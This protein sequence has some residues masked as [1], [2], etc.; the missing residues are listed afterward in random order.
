MKGKPA[1]AKNQPGQE[2]RR[3]DSRRGIALLMI[4][5][6]L[7]VLLITAVAF[8][9]FM[10]LE[11]AG[12]ANY[13]H[14]TTARHMLQAGL[15][16]AIEDIHENAGQAPYP[17]FDRLQDDSIP[18]RDH[19]LPSVDPEQVP[20]RVLSTETML[21]VPHFLRQAMHKAS[22]HWVPVTSQNRLVGRYAYI[23]ANVSGL[24][25]ANYAGGDRD[26]EGN[27]ISRGVGGNPREIRL[28]QDLLPEMLD[29]VQFA[30]ER[31]ER[32]GRYE[33][34]P[35]LRKLN[36]G[37][38]GNRLAHFSVYSRDPVPHNFTRRAYI[39]EDFNLWNEA[40]IRQALQRSG[41]P[42]LASP[43][44]LRQHDVALLAMRDFVSE[45]RVPENFNYPNIK[46]VPK[47]CTFGVTANYTRYRIP[48]TNPQQY[49]HTIQYGF[50]AG[51]AVPYRTPPEGSY[52][53]NFRFRMSDYAFNVADDFM[54]LTPL[55]SHP[56][57]TVE[58]L[59][60][61]APAPPSAEQ[62]L[63]HHTDMQDDNLRYEVVNTDPYPEMFFILRSAAEVH[64]DSDGPVDKA[65]AAGL[66]ANLGS[67]D[68][69]ANEGI[70]IVIAIN[71]ETID[72][73]GG[74]DQASLWFWSETFDPR[75]NWHPA[76]WIQSM[77]LDA[78]AAA[79]GRDR[80]RPED[81]LTHY[82][83]WLVK[84][85]FSAG[86]YAERQALFDAIPSPA[87][88]TAEFMDAVPGVDNFQAAARMATTP[89]RPFQT[90][91]E[92]G[93]I[94][95]GPWST[96]RL[97]GFRREQ[98]PLWS[99]PAF[100]DHRPPHRVLDNFTLLEEAKAVAGRVNINTRMD[101]VLA[102]VFLDMPL[103]ETVEDQARIPM[104]IENARR[105][106]QVLQAWREPPDEEPRYI[107]HLSD[108]GEIFE[109]E[110]GEALNNLIENL[111]EQTGAAG[112][113]RINSFDREAIIRNS[114]GLFSLR[115]QLYL[116][117]MRADAFAPRFGFT[118]IEQGTVLAT[119]HAVALVW[120]D[121]LPDPGDESETPVHPTLIRMFNMLEH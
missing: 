104:D 116:V 93:Y 29:P 119:G 73:A 87:L 109:G 89:N 97:D 65:P 112:A 76:L 21:H 66:A 100:T 18:F 20:A 19:V 70:P 77:M 54:G 92:L 63:Y 113:N 38:D 98:N 55:Q 34:L 83:T 42:N 27:P 107:A 15:A 43:G 86:S 69:V 26:E 48:E 114:S 61:S 53:M 37:L 2:P 105:L 47:I 22:P 59:G 102:S 60:P 111:I 36:Q 41:V 67:S 94:L 62:Q 68:W 91:G 28:S 49:R 64:H 11:R 81:A 72:E 80:A 32:H 23:V 90:V 40:R 31:R 57:F 3:Q 78:A 12:A 99:M 16:R 52:S 25:D 5:G 51:A 85:A 30:R 33:N 6:V 82:P 118:D 101:N 103:R 10:R 44:G 79:T 24:L 13:R 121:S 45:G 9:I 74:P 71:Q 95:I 17:R 120:R 84:Q 106:D 14:G 115:D 50:I 75:F 46:P 56:D 1:M 108:L 4:L 117:I 58:S 96:I 88:D 35:E 110:S 39:G 8:A 7:A